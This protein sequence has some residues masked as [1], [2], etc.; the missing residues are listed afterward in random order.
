MQK[1]Q[2][3]HEM[4]GLLSHSTVGT[5]TPNSQLPVGAAAVNQTWCGQTTGTPIPGTGRGGRQNKVN[6]QELLRV[7]LVLLQRGHGDTAGS[8]C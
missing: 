8:G 3:N 4:C 5:S 7:C 1:L 6:C 2:E